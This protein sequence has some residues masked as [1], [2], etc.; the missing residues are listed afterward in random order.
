MASLVFK[1]T[2]Q[3]YGDRRRLSDPGPLGDQ[4]LQRFPAHARPISQMPDTPGP[5]GGCWKVYPR[6]YDGK[7]NPSGW[8]FRHRD[9]VFRHVPERDAWGQQRWVTRGTYQD[10]TMFSS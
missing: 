1:N 9:Q 8:G 10:A 4:Y 3:I 6:D 2:P 5:H 7:T